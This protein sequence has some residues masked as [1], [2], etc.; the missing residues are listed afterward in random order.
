MQKKE[1]KKIN[2]QLEDKIINVAYG[3]CSFIDWLIVHWKSMHNHEVKTLLNEY[4]TTAD[5]VHKIHPEEVSSEFFNS[6]KR[7]TIGESSP[8]FLIRFTSE[9]FYSILGKK[10]I[11][12]T[13]FITILMVAVYFIFRTP[14]NSSKYSSTEIKLA[15]QHF[16]QTLGIIGN[17]FEKAEKSFNEDVLNNQINKNLNRGYFLVNNILIGG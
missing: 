9:L 8:N 12:A 13:V 10:A 5:A 6:I 3:D 15:Q 16:K 4:S 2:Q 14:D 17:A 1:S 7:K 11:P